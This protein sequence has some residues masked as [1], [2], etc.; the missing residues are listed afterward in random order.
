[1]VDGDVDVVVR[2]SGPGVPRR[3]GA[4]DLPPG[5]LD[6]GRVTRGS[7]GSACRW[8]TWS[9]RA[10]AATWPRRSAGGSTLHRPPARRPGAGGR[11]IG[12]LIVD[13][14]FMVAKVHAGF[15]GGARRLRGRRDGVHRRGRRSARD[16]PPG[17]RPGAAR[18]LPAGHDRPGGAAPA[19]CR[20]V[21]GRRHRHQRRPGRRQ[22][23]QRAARRGAALPGEAL[24]PRARS[25]RGCATTPSLRG[26]LAELDGGRAGRRRPGVRRCRGRGPSS[27]PAPTPKGIAPETLEL[28][29]RRPGRRRVRTACRRPSAASAP[30]WPG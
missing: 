21:A 22:H 12:V 27:P 29:R 4:G 24:R 1:M 19:A 23:P 18:R 26:E 28:V 2:D 9:A 8:S 16:R 5:G 3:H 17:A 30:G 20:R 13:D 6:E 25:R 14:D 11:M 15:V 7:A 10:G